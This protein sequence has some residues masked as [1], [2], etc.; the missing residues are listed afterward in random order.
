MATIQEKLEKQIYNQ[1]NPVIKAYNEPIIKAGQT[2]AQMSNYYNNY[3]S[4]NREQL[5]AMSKAISSVVETYKT[6][7]N[8]P[9][10]NASREI[11][12][13]FQINQ[14]VIS[15]MVAT[16]KEVY[17]EPVA[18]LTS[19]MNNFFEENNIQINTLMQNINN[20]IKIPSIKDIYSDINFDK[21][22]ID[23]AGTI[24]YEGA[25]FEKEAIEEST[26]EIIEDINS[27]NSININTILK[28][29][30]ISFLCCFVLIC[31]PQEILQWF[32]LALDEGFKGYIGAKMVMYIIEIFKKKY[33]KSANKDKTYFDT[34]CAMI[35]SGKLKVRKQPDSKEQVI[36]YLYYSQL[37]HIIETKPYWA[38]IEYKDKE[39]KISISGWVSTKGLK[40]FN[41]LTSQ[42]EDIEENE[43]GA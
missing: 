3:F 17:T 16:F 43:I 42:F 6:I 11:S 1:I 15:N 27:K 14:E 39:N 36:G 2:I 37:V 23:N 9:I 13:Y 8:E 18:K 21:I 38:K 19:Q 26:K 29:I 12:N 32:M 31:F 40:K 34:H 7:Y 4:E 22:S 30:I 41:T 20:I 28:K 10:I 24:E 5:L 35:D 25:I 33:P